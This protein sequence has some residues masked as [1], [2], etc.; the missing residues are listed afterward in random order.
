MVETG[1]KF[2]DNLAKRIA[3]A[4]WFTL[5]NIIAI[6]I[7]SLRYI[8]YSGLADSSLG[9]IYQFIS[10]IGH[11]S[12]LA[13]LVFGIFLFPLA[14]LISN[15]LIYRLISLLIATIAITF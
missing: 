12:F 13:A 2:Y 5:F 7:I 14:F 9:I 4:H 6:S 10:L 3:W 8:A 1:H 15:N 11:F